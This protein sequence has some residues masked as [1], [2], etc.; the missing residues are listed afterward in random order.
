VIVDDVADSSIFRLTQLKEIILGEG[1]RAVQSIPLTTVNW[2]VFYPRTLA[3]QS[4]PVN[5]L[6]D[7]GCLSTR[8]CRAGRIESVGIHQIALTAL[9]TA[10]GSE[11]SRTRK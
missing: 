4:L 7:H 2:W 11:G 5:T 3:F 6:S 10:Y 9:A 8:S 1:V